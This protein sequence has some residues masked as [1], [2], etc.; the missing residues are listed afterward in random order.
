VRPDLRVINSEGEILQ[1]DPLLLEHEELK[2]KYFGL[3]GQLGTLKKELAGMRVVEPEAERIQETL[4][5]WR[6]RCKPRAAICAGGK[7]WEKTRARLREKLDNRP[8]LTPE[9]LKRAVDGALLDRWHTQQGM[10]HRLDAEFLFRSYESVEKLR[11]IALGFEGQAGVHLRDLLGVSDELRF[12]GWG[13][14]LEVCMCSHRRV[15]HSR[16]DPHREGRQPC[17]LSGCQCEDW[18]F[19]FADPYNLKRLNA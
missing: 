17:L 3:L 5:Y 10:S 13:F 2:L 9:E 15:E 16:S 7:R 4:D 6:E 12:V 14:L 8:P 1:D 18:D 19:D 11:D